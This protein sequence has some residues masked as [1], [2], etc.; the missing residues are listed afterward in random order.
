MQLQIPSALDD[1][2]KA[3]DLRGLE[4]SIDILVSI[5]GCLATDRVTFLG[6][7]SPYMK[8][9]VITNSDSK[10]TGC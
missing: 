9:E 3:L 10:Y 1:F 6:L 8:R 5:N 2:R 7:G 4:G